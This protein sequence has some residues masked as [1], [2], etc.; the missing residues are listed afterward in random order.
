MTIEEA[1]EILEEIK[2]IIPP[3]NTENTLTNEGRE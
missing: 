1:T 3:E 2:H